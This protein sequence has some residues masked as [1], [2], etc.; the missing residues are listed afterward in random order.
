MTDKGEHDGWVYKQG[1]LV[2]N[3]K[4]RFMVL[5]GKQLTYYDT[6]QITARTKEKGS[7]QVITVELSSDL[8]NG[9]I[10][11]GRGGR[12]LKLYTESAEST[13]GWFRAIMDATTVN[14]NVSAGA[15]RF[16]DRYST[17]SGSNNGDT[18]DVDEQLDLLER[19]ESLPLEDE[20]V[21]HSGW[22]TKEGMR[23]KSWKRR[24]FTLR[25]DTLSYFDSA[26]TGRNAKGY[27]HVRAVEVN[28]EVPNS[29]DVRFDNNRILRVRAD[30][31][32]D[33]Q[34]WL[35]MLSDAIE[36][37][38]I[39]QSKVRQSVAIRQSLRTSMASNP[40]VHRASVVAPTRHSLASVPSGRPSLARGGAKIPAS[41]SYPTQT[42]MELSNDSYM[43]VYSAQ[44]STLSSD[45]QSGEYYDSDDDSD[46]DWI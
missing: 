34:E 11:H 14:M 23:V 25:G 37:A 46:G 4:R 12:V 36:A 38:S 43:S 20:Q 32:E 31:P 35:C 19:L 30:S 42:S 41:A 45:N 22:L 40:K 8:Q 5:R 44:S 21:Q 13:N 39:D 10:V 3:W 29:L 28:G 6:A 26:D 15:D 18:V 24:Y 16:S 33:M 7:F 2:K 1:S 9:L 27:G 17:L